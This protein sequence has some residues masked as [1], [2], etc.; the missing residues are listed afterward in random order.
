M[1]EVVSVECIEEFDPPIIR[2]TLAGLRSFDVSTGVYEVL[3]EPLGLPN[4]P[5]GGIGN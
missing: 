2:I 5:C 4:D 1:P 3:K